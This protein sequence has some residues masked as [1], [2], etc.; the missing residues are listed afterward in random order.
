MK[1]TGLKTKK[2]ET[3]HDLAKMKFEQIAGLKKKA[4]KSGMPYG[5]LKKFTIEE[6]PL[7]EV[8]TDQ[9]LHSNNGHLLE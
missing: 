8:D 7:G 1:K 4:E 9:V 2:E 3:K 6:W 5:I